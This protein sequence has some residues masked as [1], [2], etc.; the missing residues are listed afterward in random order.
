MFR[1]RAAAFVPL[2]A[3][4]LVAS[5]AARR[6]PG[7]EKSQPIVD[8][9][10]AAVKDPAKPFTMLVHLQVKEGDGEKLEAAFAKAIK[11]TRKEK[12]CLTYDLSRDAKT[13][14]HYLV[15]ERWQNVDALDAHLKT[16]HITALLTE[17]ADL[18]ASPPEVR[19]HVPAGD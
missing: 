5:L 19:V 15:Y 13:P 14:T 7:E 10:K 9:V 11:P 16:A 18:L 8:Q 2:V 4:L 12:G 6:A 17:L 1:L 3:A